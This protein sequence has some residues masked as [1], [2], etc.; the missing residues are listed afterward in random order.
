MNGSS[1]L[2]KLIV[3][4]EIFSLVAIT[5]GNAYES[6]ETLSCVIDTK[7][8]KTNNIPDWAMG[9]F[10]GTFGKLKFGHLSEELGFIEGYWESGVIGFSSFE[11]ERIQGEFILNQSMQLHWNISAKMFSRY[12]DTYLSSIFYG[13]LHK[14]A[15]KK[16]CLLIGFGKLFFDGTLEFNIYTILGD[17]YYLKGIWSEFQDVVADSNANKMSAIFVEEYQEGWPQTILGDPNLW[18]GIVSPVVDDLDYD[19]TKEIILTQQ[20]N[21][22]KLY[23]FCYNGSLKFPVIEI[24]GDISPRTFTSVADIDNDGSKEI[25]VD[26]QNTIVIY[27]SDGVLKDI[28]ILNYQVSDAS[29][30]RAPVL[31]DVNN[32]DALELIYGGWGI[33]G[34][35]LF[36]LN[37]QGVVI[38]GF[39]IMLENIQYS[40]VSMPAVGNFDGDTNLEIVV[41]SHE[42]NQPTELSNIRV[43]NYD[44]SM[45]W[46][47]QIDAM[48]FQSPSVGDVNNDGFD[49]VIFTSTKGVHI[50][51]RFGNYLV[52][53]LL[54]SDGSTSNVALGDIDGNEYLEV[55]FGYQSNIYA[56]DH[57]GDILW[58]YNTGYLT[59]YPPVVEDI[60][61][62][63]MP[64]VVVT[65]DFEVFAWDFQGAIIPGFPLAI[66]INAYGACS[67]ADVDNDSDIELIASA[68]WKWIKYHGNDCNEGIIYIWDL[69]S[70]Y[71]ASSTEWPMFHHDLR[72]TGRYKKDISDNLP[73]YKP[74]IDGPTNGN[75]GTSY[76]Y[77]FNSI[78]PE[79]NNIAEYMVN[80]G[81]GTNTSWE[82]PFA[83]GDPQTISHT[84]AKKGTYTIS[85]KAKDIY[86]AESEWGT[87]SVRMPCS[88]SISFEQLLMQ[89]FE[90]FP[91]AFPMLRQMMGY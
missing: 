24:S 88:Y 16:T 60:T 26:M 33:D 80:W 5:L 31:A 64:D 32:D 53:T 39:P 41:I 22:V 38:T 30:Y 66:E 83:S 21:P 51:D 89:F 36:V 55:I 71:N 73:P 48:V 46:S 85:A 44:G 28:W 23:V 10:N 90:R 34:C 14:I 45:L 27:G 13:R 6:N 61:G 43:F 67:V 54:G 3:G 2:K 1:I 69:T 50:L 56:M 37:N 74:D 65:S 77:T 47:Q 78:D 82:G 15:E 68:D 58:S 17:N 29:I 86:D 4:I 18:G 11:K 35:R 87:L 79:G 81:D 12:H 9:S 8:H 76:I 7:I 75:A 49:E 91:H 57:N 20:S 52:N 70:T 42:N 19:G 62:D 40:E 59:H 72:H 25:I 63:S 84:W